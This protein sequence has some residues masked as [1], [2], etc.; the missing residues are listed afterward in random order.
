MK[1]IELEDEDYDTLIELCNELRT[2]EDDCQAK[3]I[4]WSPS[5]Y[6]PVLNYH[7]EGSIIEVYHD[8]DT[9]S[10]EG[11]AEHDDFELYNT[12]LV[13]QMECVQEESEDNIKYTLNK[14]HTDLE[15]AWVGYIEDTIVDADIITFDLEQQQESNPSLFKSDVKNFINSNQHHLGERPHTYANTIWRMRK[16]EKLVNILEKIK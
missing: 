2:Q 4:F 1:T 6:K 5:S 3:P 8:G 15:D 11:F 14:Y 10:S 13:Y 9:Y 12:W 16:M 7:G